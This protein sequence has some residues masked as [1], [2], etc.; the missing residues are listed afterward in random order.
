MTVLLELK[1]K[2]KEFYSE[3]D[4]LLLSVFKFFLAFLLFNSINSSLGFMEKLDNIFIVLILSIICA[5]LPVNVMTVIGCVLIVL[6]CYAVGLEVAGF[7][8]L[9]IILLLILFL[10]F[11]SEDNLALV[12]TPAAFR[13]HISAA[14]PI[15]GGLLRGPACVVPAGCGVILYFFMQVVKDKSTVLQGKETEAVQKLQILLD[16]LMKNQEMWLNVLAFVV[17]LM[18]VY[19]ISRCSFDYSWRVANAVGA[20]VY[21]VIMILGGMFLNV[22]ISMGSVILSAV[23]SLIIGFVLEFAVLGVDYSRSEKTQFE[24]DEY[25]YYVKAV[26]KSYVAQKEKSIK[27]ISSDYD[28]KPEEEPDDDAIPVERVNEENIDFEKQLEESLKDL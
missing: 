20:V 23:L 19:T 13:F 24:D 7:A 14:V 5:V 6:H 9:L 22:D 1:Q 8:A 17:V 4:V 12:L 18:L 16:G 28:R 10:R 2:I 11:T 27:T 3:H 26:P 25:V 15:G 21:I